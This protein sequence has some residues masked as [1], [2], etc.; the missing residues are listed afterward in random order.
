MR[1]R[2]PRNHSLG[3]A[4]QTRPRWGQRGRDFLPGMKDSSTQRPVT[5]PQAAHRHNALVPLGPPGVSQHRT[6]FHHRGGGRRVPPWMEKGDR[7][8]LKG[9]REPPRCFYSASPDAVAGGR[10]SSQ[11]S[12]VFAVATTT[13]KGDSR[14]RLTS[15]EPAQGLPG[16]LQRRWL[17]R[18]VFD[19]RE[20]FIPGSPCH[21]TL[22]SLQRRCSKK[23]HAKE[24]RRQPQLEVARARPRG[25]WWPGRERRRGDCGC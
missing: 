2:T 12:R 23:T 8:Q 13:R 20:L 14:T 18:T 6:G 1:A 15:L 3:G 9:T 5:S 25:A 4:E 16:G 17:N 7:V 21:P 10:V 22:S 24:E 11:Q 19:H